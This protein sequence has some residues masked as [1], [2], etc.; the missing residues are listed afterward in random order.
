MSAI[1]EARVPFSVQPCHLSLSF[2]SPCLSVCLWHLPASPFLFDLPPNLE[3]LSSCFIV[4]LN[5]PC[6]GLRF[7]KQSS[8]PYVCL[9]PGVYLLLTLPLD[10]FVRHPGLPAATDFS[11]YFRFMKMRKGRV[12]NPPSYPK[13]I[14]KLSHLSLR[15]GVL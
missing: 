12:S 2:R 7:F 8:I 9:L 5:I 15:Y 11:L 4:L 14:F 3:E 6:Q 13:A 1:S 10:S